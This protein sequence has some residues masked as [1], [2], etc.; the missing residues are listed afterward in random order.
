MLWLSHAKVLVGSPAQAGVSYGSGTRMRQMKRLL[1]VLFAGLIIVGLASRP[2]AA[3]TFD[4]GVITPGDDSKGFVANFGTGIVSFEDTIRFS[5]TFVGTSL[6]GA[7]RDASFGGVD[8][9]N[10]QLD[11]FDNF[12]PA[13]SLG[14]FT[15]LSGTFSYLN[16]AAGD[17]F[18]RVMGDT[19]RSGNVYKYRFTA[20]T[21]I[22]IP[23]ALLLFAT[24]IGGLWLIGYR[25]RKL[26]S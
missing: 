4:L 7:V 22:P 3:S 11:L 16:L 15:D 9:V 25:R 20:G 18:L 6:V 14:T 1:A 5:L 24:A 2:A 19:G 17:Y 10:F 23:P 21:E 12:D 26:G 13:S 8:S